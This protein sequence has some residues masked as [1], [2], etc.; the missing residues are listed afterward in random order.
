MSEL[1]EAP[2]IYNVETLDVF[3][4]DALPM[5]AKHWYEI[6]HYSDIPLDPDFDAYRKIEANGQLRIFTVRIG[7]VLHGYAVFVVAA[8]AHYRTS[9]QA[10]QDVLYI[11]PGYRKGT[12]GMRLL[13]YSENR[14]REEGVE[15]VYHH[16]KVK[17][18]VLGV[19]LQ[20]MGYE[21][22]DAIYARRININNHQAAD[23]KEFREDSN[24]RGD[25]VTTDS[26]VPFEARN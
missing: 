19:L 3:L 10:T 7:G 11:D 18:P 8:N 15:V 26:G 2:T 17:H 9:L 14:L 24:S 20:R 4:A 5:L 22:V 21:V 1:S 16:V 23:G 25:A 6:A 12:F 13:W